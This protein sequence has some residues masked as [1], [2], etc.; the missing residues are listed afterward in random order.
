M[1]TV[2][3]PEP[4]GY[5]LIGNLGAI[6]T[7]FP[8]RSFVGFA[9]KY[10]EIYRLRLPGRSLVVVSTH[11]LVNE[12]CD[13]K[14]FKKVPGGALA[15]IREGVHDGLFTAHL[16]EENWG[17]AHRVLMPAFGPISIRGMFDEM[18]DIA[19]QL[20]MKWA[21]Y[22]PSHPIMVTDDF[23]RLTLDTLALCSMGYRFNS[24]Y[25]EELHPFIGAMGDF[26]TESGARAQRPPLPSFF[27]RTQ[28]AKFA[29]DIDVLRHTAETVLQERKSGGDSERK[30]LLSAMLRGIDPKLGVTM[31][32]QSI[33]DNLIT[34]L[35]AGHETTS[36]LLSFAFYQLLKHPEAYR[37]AQQEVDS[38]IG[39]GPIKVSR[40]G[41]T[42]AGQLMLTKSGRSNTCPNFHISPP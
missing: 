39:K 7:T 30:D 35:I 26:L 2:P 1:E 15:Q 5:P 23:T 32:D 10:G 27:Y 22:G 3:I 42:R 34:F 25:S 38:V 13:E 4:P 11:A 28:D 24:Y 41:L 29:A 31:T 14:R 20:T 17:I 12:V 21:R 6:D 36:G 40:L 37:K 16:E 33:V 8:L 9:E 19:T 18:H